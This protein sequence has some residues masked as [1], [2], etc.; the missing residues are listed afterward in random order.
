MLGSHVR[1][2]RYCKPEALLLGFALS[3]L[4]KSLSR[5]AWHCRSQGDLN[6]QLQTVLSNPVPGSAWQVLKV[7]GSELWHIAAAWG[8]LWEGGE[9][10]A[11]CERQLSFIK[12][13]LEMMLKAEML[14]T[15]QDTIKFCEL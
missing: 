15:H 6:L 9:L 7:W 14:E 10:S 8:V 1:R 4:A 3:K 12:V 11:G 5:R 2:T 13:S